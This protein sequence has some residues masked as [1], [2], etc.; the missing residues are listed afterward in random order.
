MNIEVELCSKTESLIAGYTF[1]YGR[2]FSTA[3]N[4]DMVF[5]FTHA[6]LK[7]DRCWKI[8]KDHFILPSLTREFDCRLNARFLAK[9][10]R[11]K[12]KA[13]GYALLV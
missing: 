11:R 9:A 4:R 7:A 13:Q 12:G 8:Y 3:E 6:S 5:N 10:R 1:A 2:A